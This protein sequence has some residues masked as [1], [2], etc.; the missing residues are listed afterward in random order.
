M[1]CA[2]AYRQPHMYKALWIKPFGGAA[3]KKALKKNANLSDLV[4]YL[5][6][7]SSDQQHHK[8]PTAASLA[9]VAVSRPT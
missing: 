4:S 6:A 9:P 2:G 7:T 8:A 5:V 3:K 1:L